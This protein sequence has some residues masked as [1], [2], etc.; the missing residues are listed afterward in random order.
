MRGLTDCKLYKILQKHECNNLCHMGFK[1]ENVAKGLMK[2][3]LRKELQTAL[4]V[5]YASGKVMNQ[6]MVSVVLR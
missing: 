6:N 2:P 3:A 4:M 5:Q 1:S